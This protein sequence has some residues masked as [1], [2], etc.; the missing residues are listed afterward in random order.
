[1]I[2][3]FGIWVLCIICTSMIAAAKGYNGFLWGLLGFFFGIFAL[4]V[5]AVMPSKN[6]QL[7]Q[8]VQAPLERPVEGPQQ[9]CPLC[10]SHIP[11]AA[12]V[13]RFCQRDVTSSSI[14]I[15]P[16]KV[17]GVPVRPPEPEE[18]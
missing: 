8:I 5:A 13:C 18:S 17:Y 15:S 4:I 11:A 16:H 14:A 7:V 10:F 3:L 12:T 6:P 2:V 9:T 1:M